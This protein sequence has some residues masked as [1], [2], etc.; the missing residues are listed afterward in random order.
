MEVA[1]LR[2]EVDWS[3]GL[4]GLSYAVSI[5]GWDGA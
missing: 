4:S 2:S 1:F 3:M 5:D